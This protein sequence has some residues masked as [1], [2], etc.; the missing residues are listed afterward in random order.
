M[1]GE[2][3][4]YD[5]TFLRMVSSALVKTMSRCIT[6]I[7]YFED[8]KIRTVVPFYMSMGGDERFVLD[9]FVD[10]IANARI[11]LNTDQIPRGTITFNGF[12]TITEEFANPN[13]YIA[14]KTVINGQM[15]SFLQKTKGIPIKV[16]YE[17]DI[18]LISEIDIMKCSEKIMHMLFNYMHFNFDYHGL[19]IDSVFALPDDK[20]IEIIREQNLESEHKKHIKF[21]L[22]VQTYYPSFF[23][24][25]DDYEICD[26]DDNI[27]WSRMCKT[28]PSERDP[29]DLHK[30]RPVYWKSY[31]WDIDK[32]PTDAENEDRGDTPKENF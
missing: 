25:T 6:W 24:D 28:K 15:K 21:T 12:N 8:S 23:E 14:K 10:D 29:N 20:Q 11:E 32:E 16:N 5:D 7:N 22:E 27:D 1:I 9:A 3:R 31:I 13:Q 18:V 26:N 17:I 4:N 2:Q 30:I 19:K